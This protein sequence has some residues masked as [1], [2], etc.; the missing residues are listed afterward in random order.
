M[1]EYQ[2]MQ[3][4]ETIANETEVE[5]D[6]IEKYQDYAL[7]AWANELGYE[8]DDKSQSYVYMDGEA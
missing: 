7:D 6:E 4:I 1:S 5:Q 2:R 8:W 3:A